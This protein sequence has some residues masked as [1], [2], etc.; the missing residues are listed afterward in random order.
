MQFPKLWDGFLD[1]K[2]EF[3]RAFPIADFPESNCHPVP[4]LSF[5]KRF[6]KAEKK[7][8]TAHQ[9]LDDCIQIHLILEKLI[10]RPGYCLGTPQPYDEFLVP[11]SF[12]DLFKDPVTLPQ[13][14]HA[15]DFE[16]EQV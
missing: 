5:M 8:L 11:K 15:L 10:A 7:G 9:G 4:S 16:K 2:V 12:N 13:L 14:L 6:T 1:L 3:R